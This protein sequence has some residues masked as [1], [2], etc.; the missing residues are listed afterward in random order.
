MKII[1]TVYGEDRIY[2]DL[3]LTREL[4]HL[5]DFEEGNKQ[6]TGIKAASPAVG[7]WF[8]I[9]PQNIDWD[10]VKNACEEA[11]KTDLLEHILWAKEQIPTDAKYQAK[12]ELF[13]PEKKWNHTMTEKELRDMASRLGDEMEDE[14]IFYLE[15]AQRI[16]NGETV[17][18][19][20]EKADILPYYRQII[21]KNG[22][23]GTVGGGSAIGRGEPPA[24]IGRDEYNPDAVCSSIYVPA[25]VRFSTK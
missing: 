10:K 16:S 12:I 20:T 9:D 4:E 14:V 23:M 6:K 11:D 13:I 19:L 3:E 24:D 18:T 2:S 22:G 8:T 7:K 5:A 25:V 1:V 15:L 17:A 21:T